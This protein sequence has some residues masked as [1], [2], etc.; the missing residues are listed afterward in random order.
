MVA[1][2]LVILLGLLGQQRKDLQ[3]SAGV[4][5][6]WDPCCSTRCQSPALVP[7]LA[8]LLHTVRHYQQ[9][10]GKARRGY[11]WGEGWEAVGRSPPHCQSPPLRLAAETGNVEANVEDQLV[12]S[13]AGL[14]RSPPHCQSPA[15]RLVACTAGS[16]GGRCGI[17]CSEVEFELRTHSTFPNTARRGQGDLD[18]VSL[19]S[20]KVLCVRSS[21]STSSSSSP[22]AVAGVVAGLL[23]CGGGGGG[24][25]AN[26]RGSFWRSQQQHSEACAPPMAPHRP[27][28]TAKAPPGF[29]NFTFKERCTSCCAA[30]ACSCC[31]RPAAAIV[32]NP[33]FTRDAMSA[34]QLKSKLDK[35][36]PQSNLKPRLRARSRRSLDPLR[37]R[38]VQ[39]VHQRQPMWAPHRIAEFPF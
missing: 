20:R 17:A 27:D 18:L 1:V 36:S 4:G 5:L 22:P 9:E 35:A 39:T 7:E 12:K 16:C 38:H 6:P 15:L 8:T 10:S 34:K 13:L 19:Y 11:P 33:R 37:F 31:N 26:S 23:V 29:V 2:S 30:V 21:N 32:Y 24:F 3:V 14:L 28:T 25:C